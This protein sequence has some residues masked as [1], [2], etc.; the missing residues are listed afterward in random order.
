MFF[1]SWRKSL[2]NDRQDTSR[3]TLSPC[4]ARDNSDGLSGRSAGLSCA[5]AQ[6]G[7]VIIPAQNANT[8]SHSF[9]LR[10]IKLLMHFLRLRKPWATSTQKIIER[11]EDGCSGSREPLLDW[12][13]NLRLTS[14]PEKTSEIIGP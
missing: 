8:S 10:R 1:W 5:P 3:S 13:H 14:K 2:G 4:F 6:F 11:V 9:S 7:A 12:F